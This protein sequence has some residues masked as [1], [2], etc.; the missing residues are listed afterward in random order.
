MSHVFISYRRGDSIA[1][2]GRIRDRLVQALGRERVFV[3]LDDIPA[4]SDFVE[5]LQSKVAASRLLLAVIG[6]GWSW[7]TD[8]KGNR[9]LDDPDDFVVREIAAAL[10]NP[11]TLVMPVLIDGAKMP[12]ARELPEPLKALARRNAFELRNNVFNPDADRLIGVIR[13]TLGPAPRPASKLPWLG[14]AAAAMITAVGAGIWLWPQKTAGPSAAGA[15]RPELGIKPKSPPAPTTADTAQAPRPASTSTPPARP[16]AIEDGIARLRGVLASAEGRVRT[17]I[18]GGSKLRLG[19]QI[20]FNVRSDVPGRLVL[21]D[22]NAAGEVTQIFP[23]RFTPGDTARLSAGTSLTVP[24]VGYGFTGFKAVEPAGK[25][26]IIAVV[27]PD[28]LPVEKLGLVQAERTRGFE[29]VST[30]TAYFA[31]LITEAT[32]DK[33][34]LDGWALAIS[35]YEITQ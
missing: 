23:N 28:N 27:V 5:V 15:G 26:R 21:I 14:A 34:R 2:A 18:R 7:A 16:E 13:E 24:G 19:D 4:G 12:D 10:A 8:D 1:T 22:V 17:E 30:P 32:A 3:D 25:G 6:P 11:N 20:V 29:P 31:Q 33:G 35:E 9:R